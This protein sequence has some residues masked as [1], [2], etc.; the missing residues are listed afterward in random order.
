M[1]EVSDNI[2]LLGW[3][4]FLEVFPFNPLGRKCPDDLITVR[5]KSIMDGGARW[6][7]K[8]AGGVSLGLDQRSPRCG[9]LSVAKSKGDSFESHR[10]RHPFARWF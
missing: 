4:A 2:L 7:S 9:R 8:R 5:E 3:E 10:E 1:Q 6:Q